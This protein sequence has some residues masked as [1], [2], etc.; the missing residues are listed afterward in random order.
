MAKKNN[1]HPQNRLLQLLPAK[2]LARLKPDLEYVELEYKF[3]IAKP[4]GAMSDVY[5]VESGVV[6]LMAF[7]KTG[8]SLEVATIGREGTTG[9]PIFLGSGTIPLQIMVQIPGSGFRMSVEAFR[10]E[11]SQPGPLHDI[12]ARYT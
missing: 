10:D 8:L 9:V 3:I 2:D 4:R 7:M 6:S 5:F 11:T 1:S 12:V